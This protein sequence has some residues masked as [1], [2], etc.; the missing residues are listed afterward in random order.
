MYGETKS[1]SSEALNKAIL[2][3][4]PAV[5]SHHDIPRVYQ[6]LIQK[7]QIKSNLLLRPLRLAIDRW[8]IRFMG[9]HITH[10]LYILFKKEHQNRTISNLLEASEQQDFYRNLE[11]LK[12]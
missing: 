3:K 4:Q 11:F 9:H 8:G 7:Y 2:L 12:I 5:L 1:S 10:D 6:I